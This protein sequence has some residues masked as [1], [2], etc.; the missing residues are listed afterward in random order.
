MLFLTPFAV[1]GFSFSLEENEGQSLSASPYRQPTHQQAME[2]QC[3]EL[4][5]AEW[6]HVPTARVAPQCHRDPCAHAARNLSKR[7][8]VGECVITSKHQI[9]IVREQMKLPGSPDYVSF[10]TDF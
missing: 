5:T 7:S 1:N 8:W 6:T 4:E 2:S 3:Q 9:R 10:G